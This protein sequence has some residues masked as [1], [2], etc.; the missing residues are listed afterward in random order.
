[1]RESSNGLRMSKFRSGSHT[2]CQVGQEKILGLRGGAADLG[3]SAA[4]LFVWGTH[5]M[6]HCPQLPQDP[7][8]IHPVRH[9]T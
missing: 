8:R 2:I 9:R 3:A 6:L 1:M 5:N 4:S 7:S